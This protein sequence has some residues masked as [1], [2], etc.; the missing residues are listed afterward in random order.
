LTERLLV[1][2]L[3]GPRWRVQSDPVD[4]AAA[5]E[6]NFARGPFEDEYDERYSPS[7]G[8]ST[9]TH[10]GYGNPP[11]AQTEY[12]PPSSTFA[13]T[14]GGSDDYGA[15]NQAHYVQRRLSASTGVSGP[16]IGNPGVAGV[17]A[18]MA[19]ARSQ[20][21]RPGEIFPSNAVAAYQGQAPEG[22]YYNAHNV[23]QAVSSMGRYPSISRT[24]SGRTS[25]GYG[26]PPSAARGTSQEDYL[27]RD[28]Y[29]GIAEEE[30]SPG[31]VNPYDQYTYPPQTQGP[32][33]GYN[34]NAALAAAAGIAG[35]SS[36]PGPMTRSRSQGQQSQMTQSVYSV[37]EQSS[38]GAV[39]GVSRH[40]SQRSTGSV[41]DDIALRKR[42]LKVRIYDW[43]DRELH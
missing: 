18:Q 16:S 14:G 34:N 6:A 2:D 26:P 36:G 5:A 8:Y 22:G 7:G 37:G 39:P 30:A 38:D 1:R 17:G 32:P 21:A 43:P 3:P 9:G 28:P 27:Q 41:D 35:P 4:T 20:S 29:G 19:R 15:Y 23:P 40:A 33:H 12:P 10:G 31:L 11:M 42:V 24:P 25:S 13:Y